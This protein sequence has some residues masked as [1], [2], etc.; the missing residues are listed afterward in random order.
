MVEEDEYRA[1]YNAINERRCVFEKSVN[2]RRCACVKSK[3]FC[4]AD[5]EGVCCKSAA[6]QLLCSRLLHRMR[7]NAQ[8]TLQ[9]TRITGPL[10]HAKEIKVQ[11]GGLLGLQAVVRP[12]LAQATQVED[13]HGIVVA[14]V[15]MFGGLDN[16]PYGVINQNIARFQGRPRRPHPG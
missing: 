12:E 8:F 7:E 11:S 4:L 1:T 5:R 13:I 2:A 9:L 16:L 6:A 3:K 14:A 15:D 10:P